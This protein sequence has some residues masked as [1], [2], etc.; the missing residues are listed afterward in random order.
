MSDKTPAFKLIPGTG[1]LVDGFKFASPSVRAYFLSHAHSG[2]VLK[3]L[4]LLSQFS[5]SLAAKPKQHL[6]FALRGSVKPTAWC[7]GHPVV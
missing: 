1:F 5:V 6:D 2:E 3:P 4:H 7:R